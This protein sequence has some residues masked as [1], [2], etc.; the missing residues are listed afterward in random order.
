MSMKNHNLKIKP[1]FL[2]FLFEIGI[3]NLNLSANANFASSRIQIQTIL[4]WGG[5]TM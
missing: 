4:W 3:F 5:T 1:L 2:S